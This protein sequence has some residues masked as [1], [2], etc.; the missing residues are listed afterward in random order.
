MYWSWTSFG[1]TVRNLGA[2]NAVPSVVKMEKLAPKNRKA[3][4]S[5]VECYRI[6]DSLSGV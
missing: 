5:Y 4:P 1:R 3:I 2:V 6:N